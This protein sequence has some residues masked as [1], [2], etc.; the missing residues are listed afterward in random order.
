MTNFTKA[1]LAK[2]AIFSSD[3]EKQVEISSNV[4]LLSKGTVSAFLNEI[5]Q[6]CKQIEQ[7]QNSSYLSFYTERLVK[8]FDYLKQAVDRLNR[9]ASRTVPQY[10]SSYRFSRNLNR[11]PN[12]LK[13][14][15]FHKALRALN[16]K[17]SWLME[18]NY[19]CHDEQMKQQYL[20]VIAETEYRKQKCLAAIN[21]LE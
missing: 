8:Q 18:Q 7:H 4:F 21:E 6:T 20:K 14:E 11:L 13:L 2:C 5:K 16:E 9:S 10:R 15:E 19:Q 3:L 12:H 1:I 17:L